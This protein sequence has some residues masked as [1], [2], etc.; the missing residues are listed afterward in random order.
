MFLAA[1]AAATF[2][3]HGAQPPALR[4]RV[5]LVQ[6]DVVVVDGEGGPIR[7]LTAADFVLSDRKQP[8]AIATFE[9]ISHE[10]GVK[11]G[12]AF[13]PSLARD[14]A[15]NRTARANRLVVLVVDDLHIYRGRTD[16]AK[17]IA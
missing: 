7:G 15:D 14:V 12:L 13:P 10:D 3:A 4:S 16:R 5:D 8:Q 9:E 6:V 17:D 11:G 1:A 2:A